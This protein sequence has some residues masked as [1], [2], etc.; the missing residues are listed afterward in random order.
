MTL[1]QALMCGGVPDSLRKLA[2]PRTPWERADRV[3]R[4][5][6]TWPEWARDSWYEIGRPG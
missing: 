2:P 3:A 4:E 5:V 1:L 6:N